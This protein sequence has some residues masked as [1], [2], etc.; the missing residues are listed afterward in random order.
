[1][2]SGPILT[3]SGRAKS[4]RESSL[5]KAIQRRT[6]SLPPSLFLALAGGAIAL[7]LGLA[8]SQKKR[9]WASFA[10]LWAPTFLLLGIYNKISKIQSSEKID[11]R[12]IL[13]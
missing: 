1:M 13:H 4:M 9:S 10:G 5:T 2:E 8:V 12:S 3:E 11:P 6:S 7:S